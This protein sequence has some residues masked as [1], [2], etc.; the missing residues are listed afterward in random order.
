MQESSAASQ[1]TEPLWNPVGSSPMMCSVPAMCMHD[2][3]KLY[4][5]VYMIVPLLHTI[6]AEW[7]HTILPYRQGLVGPYSNI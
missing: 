7:L 2:G 3:S 5:Y 4:N 6:Q 1:E